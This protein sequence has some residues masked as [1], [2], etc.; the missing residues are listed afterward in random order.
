M[1]DGMW[2]LADLAGVTELAAEHQVNRST[3]CNWAARYADF[4]APLVELSTGPV[5]SRQQ[6]RAWHDGRAWQPGR[7]RLP[8]E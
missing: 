8:R 6:V 7:P 5:Y 3:V 2:D 4:P 1:A